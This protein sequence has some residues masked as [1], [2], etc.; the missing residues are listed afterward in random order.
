[1]YLYKTLTW[2][3]M[4][5]TDFHVVILYSNCMVNTVLVKALLILV[6]IKG[7]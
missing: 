2:F 7:W 3:D 4:F 6:L 5:L 1:M